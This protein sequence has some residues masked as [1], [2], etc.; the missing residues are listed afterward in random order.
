MWH[1]SEK[2]TEGTTKQNKTYHV[3]NHKAVTDIWPVLTE[4]G[5]SSVTHRNKQAKMKYDEITSHS[6]RSTHTHTLTAQMDLY[7]IHF[8][9]ITNRWMCFWY[10]VPFGDTNHFIAN[11]TVWL[12]IYTFLMRTSMRII[13]MESVK[14][15]C[16]KTI[17]PHTNTHTYTSQPTAYRIRKTVTKN[18]YNYWCCCWSQ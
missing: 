13:A 14:K 12:T 11:G 1:A 10:V 4:N 17:W 16:W 8:W 5:Q 6:D 9:Y 3:S 2:E 15:S 7:F 18:Y